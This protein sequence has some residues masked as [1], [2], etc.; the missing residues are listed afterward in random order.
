LREAVQVRVALVSARAQPLH[1]FRYQLVQFLKV[2]HWISV[3]E[4]CGI[5]SAVSPVQPLKAPKTAAS[6]R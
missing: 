4:P 6:V 3:S 1:E 2:E 5:R